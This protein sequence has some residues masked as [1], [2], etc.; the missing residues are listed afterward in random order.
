MRPAFRNKKDPLRKFI[1]GKDPILVVGLGRSGICAAN[2]LARMGC[3]V[4][5]TEQ[6]KKEDFNHLNNKLNPDVEVRWG[7]HPV[8]LLNRFALIVISPGVPVESEFVQHAYK[9]GIKV[10]GEMELAFRL[11]TIPWVAITGTNG[12][13][14]TTTLLGEFAQQ[15]GLPVG[16]GG[17]LGLPVT[18]LVARNKEISHIIAEVSSFQLETVETFKPSIGV[19]LNITPDHL[20]RYRNDKDY[21]QAKAN[22]FSVMSEEDWAVVNADDP[23][24]ETV[25]SDIDT[26]LFPFSRKR[27]LVRGAF[28]K[29]GW[30]VLRDGGED[31]R[32]IPRENISLIGTHNLENCLAAVAAGSRMGIDPAHMASVMENF[33]GLEHR[34]ELVSYL[35]GVPIYNDSKGTNV[36]ATQRSLESLHSDV[37]LIMGGKDKGT[38]YEPLR[39][40]V[41][42][43][44]S[45]L[46]LLG[47]AAGRMR[48]SLGDAADT[49][50][51]QDLEDAVKISIDRARPGSE[52]LFSP[53]S[54]S[55]DMFS[56]F[57]ER[58]KVFKKLIHRYVGLGQ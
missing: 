21:I 11:S 48:D 46:I 4:V 9:K 58:G 42:R 50:M 53:A 26:P 18:D 17:N 44:V 16:V 32:V 28:L 54:S 24:V 38:S 45:H 37:I 14:T 33:T 29:D 36:E 7:G 34:M 30:I 27:K 49:V 39:D 25:I 1:Q 56:S 8:D 13:S 10:V 22:L 41:S 3:P 35:R 23:V 6:S 40:L 12:K 31:V 2:L 19:L 57:E 15:A 5:V 43:K 20:D 52:I 55:F 51:V 47:E